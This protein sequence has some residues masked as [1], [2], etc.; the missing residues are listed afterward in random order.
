MSNRGE[1]HYLRFMMLALV[2]LLVALACAATLRGAFSSFLLVR[3]SA[4]TL[5]VNELVDLILQ[6]AQNLAFERGRSNVLL[7]AAGPAPA[8]QLEFLAARRAAAAS[9]EGALASRLAGGQGAAERARRSYGELRALRGE[10][11]AALARPL[12]ARDPALAARWFETASAAVADLGSLATALS[13]GPGQRDLGFRSYSRLKIAVLALRDSLGIEASRIAASVAAGR[14]PDGELLE[15]MR[16]RGRS[17]ALWELA[18]RERSGLDDPE[19]QA[20]IDAARS[21]CLG[22]FRSLEERVLASLR[23]GAGSPV[24]L[25]ELTSASVPA[26]DSLASLMGVL[27]DRTAAEASRLHASSL[28]RLAADLLLALLALASG[29]AA[30]LVLTRRLLNPMRHVAILLNELARGHLDIAF[31]PL[32][33]DDEM[34]RAYEAVAWLRSGLVERQ[35]LLERLEELSRSDGLTGLANR[36][37]LDELVAE[38]LRRAARQEQR[39]ALVMIDI[40]RF[41]RYNDRYGHLAG[42]ECLRRVARTLAERARRPGELAARY[43]G[44]E[45]LALLPGL[46]AD[47]ALRWAEA[48]RREIEA[49]GIEHEDSEAGVV[50]VSCGVA[51][52]VPPRGLAPEAA[53]ELADRALYRAK[54]AGRNRVALSEES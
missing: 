28:R 51:S 5:E 53:L 6:G 16:F 13:L 17:E 38:E 46:A 34:A 36:R 33:R 25:E 31:E 39:L 40:D 26:L 9:L 50:T 4:L 24:P 2:A 1:R 41:K 12:A 48:L 8:V 44:E 14:A 10:V 47:R 45:F 15:I 18:E 43:G 7:R 23:S 49:L 30:L 3:E 19:A 37:R 29:A 20:A 52:L 32:S 22:A 11:D 35:R 42:D 54:A 21:A 27:A